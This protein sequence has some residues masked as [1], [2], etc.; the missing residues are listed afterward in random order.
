MTGR[1]KPW[2]FSEAAERYRRR[3]KMD[4]RLSLDTERRLETLEKEFGL[5]EVRSITAEEVQAY[6]YA[7][8]SCKKPGTI[9]RNLS[10][11]KAVLSVALEEGMIT[12]KPVIKL[13]KVS[14]ARNTHLEAREIMPVVNAIREEDGPLMGFVV[15]LLIDTGMRFGEMLR[16]V[17]GD[18]QRDWITVRSTGKGKTKARR[19]P[20]SPR[21][22]QYMSEYG[23]LPYEGDGPNT[24]VVLSRW[25]ERP[26]TIGRRITSSLR[27]ACVSTGAMCGDEIKPHDLRHTFAFICASSGADLG[28]IKELLGHDNISMTMR[29]RGFVQV[30][31]AEAIRKGMAASDAK[32]NHEIR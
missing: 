23:I 15:L 10:V 30:R 20:T 25:T 12:T 3:L 16:L 28:D 31:A 18:L 32:F 19:I 1:R 9:N 2:L 27:K 7:K 13:R 8:Y 17:W 21:L 14:D 29:Y 11:L 26:T 4:G 24:P 6:V 22:L 5:R